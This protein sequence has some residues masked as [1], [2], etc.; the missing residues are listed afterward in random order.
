LEVGQE[1]KL[2]R[3]SVIVL[4]C[5]RVMFKDYENPL[6]EAISPDHY[7]GTFARVG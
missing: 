4:L 6:F 1:R 2:G 3:T 7:E 5:S